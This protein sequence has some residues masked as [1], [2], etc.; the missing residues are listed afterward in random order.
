MSFQDL[1]ITDNDFSQKDIYADRVGITPSANGVTAN[2]LKWYFTAPVKE[3]MKDFHNG[4]ISELIENG[5]DSL[6][7]T[8]GQVTLSLQDFLNEVVHFKANNMKYLDLN[9]DNQ[10][11]VSPDGENWTL[12]ASSGHIIQDYNGNELIQR[13]RMRFVNSVVEDDPVNGVTIVNGIKGDKGDKGDT[14]DPGRDG[15]NGTPGQTGATGPRG[16]TGQTGAA[17]VPSLDSDGNLSW[18]KV[19]AGSEVTPATTNIRGPQGIQGIQGVAG[20]DGGIGPAGPQGIQGPV[21]PQG[22][23]GLDGADGRSFSILGRYDHLYELEAEHP[24]GTAGDAWA[25]GSAVN[26]TIYNWDTR[27]ESWVDLGPLRGPQ[28][29]QGVQGEQG[30]QG[31]AGP[32]GQT[33]QQGVPGIQGEQGIQGPI[34]PVGPRGYPAKVNGV[35]PDEDGEIN[36]TASDVGATIKHLLNYNDNVI[37]EGGVVVSFGELYA[38]LMEGMDFVVLV[39]NDRAYHP[40]VVKKPSTGDNKWRVAFNSPIIDGVT[41]KVAEIECASAD[42]VTMESIATVSV[43]NENVSNKQA[44]LS[45]T[46]STTYYPSNK[47]VADYVAPIAEKANAAY[48]PTNK[49]TATD[50]GALPISGG[51][52]TGGLIGISNGYDSIR[53]D[54]NGLLLESFGASGRPST[55]RRLVWIKSRTQAINVANSLQYL[56]RDNGGSEFTYNIYGEHNKSLLTET[57]K[58]LTLS[59]GVSSTDA[60]YHKDADGMV[61]VTGNIIIDSVTSSTAK[62]IATLPAGYRPSKTLYSVCVQYENRDACILSM[63]DNGVLSIIPN[64]TATGKTYLFSFTFKATQ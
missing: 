53:G 43:N 18:I 60:A 22:Q 46:T 19:D 51:T 26:N 47:A 2:E 40:T 27:T 45:N 25:V 11:I 41:S 13:P 34:G 10:I 32:A 28:G 5:A 54:N 7:V 58:T 29:E 63:R 20:R 37:T 33:G 44:S 21:G 23:R 4:L 39:Y 15:I 12:T 57:E 3:V 48:S 36:L 1:Y 24:T 56:V 17:F 55:D 64:S 14:G 8:N 42:G 6:T 30:I 49:P 35:S 50:V 59:Q 38:M 9:A 52:L 16:Y 62:A 31:P 61:T